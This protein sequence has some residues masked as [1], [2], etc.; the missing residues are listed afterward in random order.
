M[1]KRFLSVITMVTMLAT[2]FCGT[3]LTFAQAEEAYHE[4]FSDAAF[5]AGNRIAGVSDGVV[6]TPSSVNGA[7]WKWTSTNT[8]PTNT[9][10]KDI[11]T[12]E[13]DGENKVAKYNH[14]TQRVSGT[15]ETNNERYGLVFDEA[16]EGDISISFKLKGTAKAVYVYVGDD[17]TKSESYTLTKTAGKNETWGAPMFKL[18][19]QPSSVYGAYYPN[20]AFRETVPN[21]DKGD[22]NF[23]HTLSE[24]E[25]STYTISINTYTG[26]TSFACDG[27]TSSLD[28]CAAGVGAKV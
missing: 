23:S 14:T 18:I 15:T 20:A 7:T 26:E 22:S 2:L 10:N 25:W 1:L 16:L 6:L 19:Q 21:S 13:A 5:I 11:F 3:T 4:D 24:T 12:T 9:N 27:T 17:G 8:N 28:A